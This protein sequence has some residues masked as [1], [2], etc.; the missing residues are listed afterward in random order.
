M[1]DWIRN[2]LGLV[3]KEMAI[4]NIHQPPSATAA[5]HAQFRLKFQVLFYLKLVK[6]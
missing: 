6:F 1:P 2:D 4:Y 5:K 3:G